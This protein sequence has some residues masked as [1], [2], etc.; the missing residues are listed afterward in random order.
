MRAGAVAFLQKPVDAQQ[1]LEAIDAA[2]G[3]VGSDR[4]SVI[5]HQ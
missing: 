3:S 1:L 4:E 5:S 2:L